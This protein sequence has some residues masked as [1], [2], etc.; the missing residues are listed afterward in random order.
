[1]ASV[2]R[3]LKAAA[4]RAGIGKCTAH[5]LRHSAAV[6]MAESG[7][8]MDEIAQYLGHSKVDVTRRIYA[9]FSPDH[10]RAAAAALELTDLGR[11]RPAGPSKTAGPAKPSIGNTKAKLVGATGIEPVTPTMSKK[12]AG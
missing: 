6:C 4:A 8:A 1:V 9:R 2:K 10:L 5:M 11:V 7:V 3:G 12:R